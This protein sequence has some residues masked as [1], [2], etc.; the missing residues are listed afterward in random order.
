[1]LLGKLLLLTILFPPLYL[2]L[3][4]FCRSHGVMRIDGVDIHWDTIDLQTVFIEDIEKGVLLDAFTDIFQQDIKVTALAGLASGTAADNGHLL[5]ADVLIRKILT[6]LLVHIVFN[7]LLHL[8]LS[9]VL[10]SL[11]LGCQLQWIHTV[12]EVIEHTVRHLFLTVIFDMKEVG[13]GVPELTQSGRDLLKDACFTLFFH[14]LLQALGTTLTAILGQCLGGYLVIRMEIRILALHVVPHLRGVLHH[15]NDLCPLT[16]ILLTQNLCP[17][18]GV[19]MDGGLYGSHIR[20]EIDLP[21]M[22]KT[23][24]LTVLVTEQDRLP[25]FVGLILIL[26]KDTRTFCGIGIYRDACTAHQSN[27]R[28]TQLNRRT[29]FLLLLS[30][31]L[32]SNAYGSDGHRLHLDFLGLRHLNLHFRMILQIVV[33]MGQHKGTYLD[34]LSEICLGSL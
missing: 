21:L 15:L 22:D 19:F 29:V 10:Q 23:I 25:A 13:N 4:P 12:Q 24:D 18:M 3:Q 9:I 5:H 26:F 30:G 34:T 16:R 17:Q 1:M 11:D 8:I 31:H 7:H 20:V 32:G 14:K 2:T 27:Q 33:R 6:E 28:I